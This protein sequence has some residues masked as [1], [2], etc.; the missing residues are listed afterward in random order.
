MNTYCGTPLTMA[1]EI[2]HGASY[3]YK[4][5]IWS[6]GGMLFTLITGVFPFFAMTREKLLS[7]VEKGQY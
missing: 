6:V 2:M 7:D 4:A 3:N 1:P 5:D